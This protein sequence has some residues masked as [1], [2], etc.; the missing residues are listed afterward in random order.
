MRRRPKRLPGKRFNHVYQCKVGQS[1]CLP[2]LFRV[3]S[4]QVAIVASSF[5]LVGRN[6]FPRLSEK[7][8]SFPV[9]P[10]A[11]LSSSVVCP[12]GQ[13]GGRAPTSYPPKV[14]PP[15][16]ILPHGRNYVGNSSPSP[17]IA[18]LCATDTK[19]DRIKCTLT[20]ALLQIC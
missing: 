8:I 16:A 3:L 2:P 17:H 1:S 11:G 7:A 4:V 14:P 12:H 18:Y 15:A 20:G 6:P 19:S 5:H 13:L 10:P 9:P